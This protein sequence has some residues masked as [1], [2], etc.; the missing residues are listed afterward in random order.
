MKRIFDL[1]RGLSRDGSTVPLELR[2]QRLRK[3][4]TMIQ[5][6]E[7]AFIAAISQD[8][9][10]RSADE[11]RV[12][13]MGMVL[14]AIRHTSS[15]L[16]RWMRPERRPV[17]MVS[18]PARAW[19]R[20]EPLGVVGI[21]APWNYPLFLSLGPLVDVLAAGNRAM[22]KPS[23]LSP[24]FS[25][26]LAQVVADT[27]AE[28][29]VRVFTG[30][31]EVAQDFSALPFD[32]LIFTGS[33]AVGRKVMQAAAANLTPVTLELGGKS[34]A[35]LCDDYDVEKAAKSVAFG[36]FLNAGQTCIA[37]DYAL[38][39]RAKV[40]TFARAVIDSAMKSYPTLAGNDDYSSIIS[41]RHHARLVA[42]VDEARAAGATVLTAGDATM[43]NDRK[44]APTV[45]IGAPETG[46]LMREEIFG[47]ILPVLPYDS[48]DQALALIKG[49]ARPLALYAYSTQQAKLDR[50]LDSAI[51]GGV[52]LNGTL[53]HAAQ[54]GMAFGGVGPS[55]MG[56]YHGRDG[57]LRFSHSRSVFKVGFVN[58][59][60]KMGP[61]WGRLARTAA[62]LLMR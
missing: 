39:P 53:I 12:L 17:S 4:K 38:V 15:H 35:I 19:V 20:R 58:G 57:F 13:E 37:P 21:I 27:F 2:Q 8:F 41:D 50:I 36:K 31:V 1:Q 5:T 49:R 42:A 43:T 40:D 33:T 7:A 47:P 46:V 32:H 30:G 56:G 25:D 22:I 54:D 16:R 55:G 9:G 3:L 44:I 24:R 6:N 28:D 34:P 23:E 45:V 59:F 60:E 61:P 11:T 48:I 52:T 51:S 26:L 18:Q 62:K 14:N 10:N 29:E